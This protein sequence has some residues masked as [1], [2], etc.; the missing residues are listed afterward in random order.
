MVHI[1]LVGCVGG[2]TIH[3]AEYIYTLYTRVSFVVR[4]DRKY[5]PATIS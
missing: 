1:T 4:L 3:C 5:E 2:Y